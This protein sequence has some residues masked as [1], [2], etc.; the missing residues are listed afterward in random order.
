MNN[1]RFCFLFQSL[2]VEEPGVSIED[3]DFC[4]T[5]MVLIIKEGMKYR[6]CSIPLPLNGNVSYELLL[7]SYISKVASQTL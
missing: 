6:L 7:V 2:L 1:F 3:I 5:H 4:D